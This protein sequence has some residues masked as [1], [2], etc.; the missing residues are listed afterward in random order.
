MDVT[1]GGNRKIHSI[2]S[3]V[4][5]GILVTAIAA[6]LS[7]KKLDKASE[8]LMSAANEY[9]AKSEIVIEL[10]NI[11][12]ARHAVLL[13]MLIE[14]DPFA[15]DELYIKHM[16]LGGRFV[17]L[18]GRL[19]ELDLNSSEKQYLEDLRKANMSSAPVQERT[20]ELVME[21]ALEEARS[22]IRQPDYIGH[23][24]ATFR[25]FDK[26]FSYYRDAN[27]STLSK[28][29]STV[30]NDTRRIIEFTSIILILCAAIG[31]FL[32]RVINRTEADLRAEVVRRTAIQQELELHRQDLEER[33]EEG[34]KE[35]EQSHQQA[36]QSEKLASVGQLAA[37]IAHEINTPIQFIGDNTRF[38]Q[39]A[40]ADLMGLVNVYESMGKAA[41]EGGV[42]AELA[43]KASALSEEIEVG[44]LAEEVPKAISQSLEGVDRV[45]KIVL[46][47]K[48]FSHPGSDSKEMID[49]NRAIESTATVSRN[50][51]K[52]NAELVTDFD[53]V[54]TAVPCY[55]GEF[56]QVVLNM[57]V[58]ASHA[59]ADTRSGD[60]DEPGTITISTRL[61]EGCAEVRI[62]DTG[63]GMPEAVSKRIFEPF[64]TTKGVGKGSGQGLA[65]AYAV[66][67]DKHGGTLEVDSAPG[68]GTTFIIRLPMRDSITEAGTDTNP[69]RSPGDEEVY[70]VC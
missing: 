68:Q 42:P 12:R 20:R 18:R 67:V 43:D 25:Q 46:S 14:E 56:N 35:L 38:L 11:A 36:L 69:D 16:E 48:D 24:L 64:Y 15:R 60:A 8:D 26:L 54:L 7:W 50:E 41:N 31:F 32:M 51:W 22:V 5:A 52:Y 17:M 19:M 70:S 55:P 57:I 53:E 6:L 58:N 27:Y 1:A 39:D 13:Y 59:I 34:R 45:T 10:W 63:T 49:I 3:M 2:L 65:I 21:G 62:K 23:R 40:F 44:Y 29:N 30:L 28:V 33:V 66:I 61:V 4:M 37:G 47:M 9:H